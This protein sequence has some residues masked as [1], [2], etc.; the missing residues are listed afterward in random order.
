MD[1]DRADEKRER[2]PCVF[3][4]V[5]LFGVFGGGGELGGTRTFCGEGKNSRRETR[6]GSEPV[7]TLV[8]RPTKRHEAIHYR[9]KQGNQTSI[10]KQ[11]NRH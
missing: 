7:R 3:V 10:I 9:G 4:L 1:R 8:S 6:G 11:L 5:S 2:R